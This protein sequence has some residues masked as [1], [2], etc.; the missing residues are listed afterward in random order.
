MANNIGQLQ[1]EANQAQ[2]HVS[3]RK[4]LAALIKKVCLWAGIVVLLYTGRIDAVAVV[5][6]LEPCNFLLEQMELF[7]GSFLDRF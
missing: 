3:M 7:A 4:K 2:S 6:V 1:A 5:L